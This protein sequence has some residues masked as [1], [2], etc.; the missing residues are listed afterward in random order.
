VWQALDKKGIPLDQILAQSLISPATC[1]L[2]NKDR[3]KTVEKAFDLTR[4]M[5]QALREEYH[6][7]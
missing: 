7:T 3:E 1:C 5:S 4:A 2:V 6:L